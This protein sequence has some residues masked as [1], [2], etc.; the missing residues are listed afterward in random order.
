MLD[1]NASV[2]NDRACR[3]LT[4]QLVVLFAAQIVAR[5]LV[6]RGAP[7]LHSAD[8]VHALKQCHRHDLHR[9]VSI[10][11]HHFT[12]QGVREAYARVKDV[13]DSWD[14]QVV[15]MSEVETVQ[16]PGA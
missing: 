2:S 6:I 10:R 5:S 16:V 14:A 4:A 11:K 15:C 12:E 3:G 8:M 13:Q 9:H 7:D 1:L